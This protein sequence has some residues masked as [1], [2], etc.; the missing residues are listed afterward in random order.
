MEVKGSAVCGGKEEGYR[1][2][3]M[4]QGEAEFR[5]WRQV[6][7][8][9]CKRRKWSAGHGVE[10]KIRIMVFGVRLGDNVYRVS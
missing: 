8:S 7:D 6:L 1:V 5:W 2:M 10:K 9:V 4:V 3:A